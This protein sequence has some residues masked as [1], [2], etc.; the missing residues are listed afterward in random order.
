M[1]RASSSTLDSPVALVNV[2]DALV[3]ELRP[4]RSAAVTYFPVRHHSPACAWHLRRLVDELRPAAVLVE[5]P[6]DFTPLLPLILN[7]GTRAPFAVYTFCVEKNKAGAGQPAA[8]FAAFYP[9]CD[10]SPELVALRAGQAAGARLRFIDLPFREQVRAEREANEEAGNGGNGLRTES[11]LHER[12]LQRSQYLR[13]LAAHTGCRDANELWDH[14]FEANFRTLTTERF[15][16]D[17]AAYCHFAR[18]DATPAELAADGT[19][20]RESAMAA[21]VAEELANPENAGRPVLVVT[22]GFH[23]VAL[24]ALVEAAA[25]RA[26]GVPRKAGDDDVQNVLVRYSFEQLDALNGYGAGMPTPGYYDRLWRA[27]REGENAAAEAVAADCLV[28]LGRLTREK[29]MVVALSSADEIAALTHARLLARLRG[30][31]GGPTREDL[32]DGVRSGCVKGAMDAEGAVLLGLAEHLLRGTAVGEV[33]PEAGVP[34]LVTDFRA[35]AVRLRLDVATSLR[36]TV[37]LDLY[38]SVAHR[39][40]SRFLHALEFLG[41]PFATV[42]GG[43]DFVRGTGLERLQ[44]HWDHAWTPRTEAAL[45]EAAVYGATVPEATANRLLEAVAHLEAEARGRDAGAAVGML[46]R[47]C[48]MGLHGEA[49]RL[50]TLTAAI[51][52]EDPGFAGVVGAANGLLLLWQSREPLEAHRLPEVPALLRAAHERACYLVPTLAA[53]PE[54]ETDAALDALGTL[55]ELLA[56]DADGNLLDAELFWSALEH[57]LAARDCRPVLRG[58]A[59]GLLSGEGRLTEAGLLALVTGHLGGAT[60]DAAAAVGFLRGLLHVRREVAWQENDG[61]LGA[62]DALLA[63]WDEGEFLRVLPEL[64]LAFAGLTPRETDRVGARVAGLHGEKTLG[65]LD[66]R[67]VRA[68]DV[69]F[70]RRVSEI[71]WQSLREDGLGAWLE[72]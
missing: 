29:R 36:K 37:A 32:L 58:A 13:A 34:P 10:Y 21:A 15:M 12:Y 23:T 6:A 51:V 19:T 30:H 38:R 69:E 33:P 72:P 61:L 53:C 5:G 65:R 64:R 71:V 46:I 3:A 25:A 26:P 11:L 55:R 14:L 35:R 49:G 39:E 42:T 41:V 31:A 16:D 70:H 57:L 8:R 27:L 48:R 56:A 62:V 44:E 50:L 67:E 54:P 24:P 4:L 59:A 66:R 18:R 2:R 7:P 52:A 1:K 43:P 20:A 22:G 63:G 68:S 47:A 9:F 40:T 28:E 17:V 45:V 60:P